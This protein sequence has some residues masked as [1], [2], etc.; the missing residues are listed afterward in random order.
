MLRIPA[1][2]RWRTRRLGNSPEICATLL[3]LIARGAKSGTFSLLAEFEHTGQPAPVA[4]EYLLITNYDHRPG[5]CVR[6]DRVELRPFEQINE[7]WIRFE[8]PALRELRAWRSVHRDYW[9]Q[10]LAGWGLEF[11]PDTPVLCQRFGPP[12]SP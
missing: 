6:L 8:G 4:G 9:T 5:C 2:V 3:D 1:N 12:F 10:M 7:E 11:G